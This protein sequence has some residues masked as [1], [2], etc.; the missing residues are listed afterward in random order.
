MFGLERFESLFMEN[1]VAEAQNHQSKNDSDSDPSSVS[2]SPSSDSANTSMTTVSTAEHEPTGYTP[3]QNIMDDDEDTCFDEVQHGFLGGVPVQEQLHNSH[4][5]KANATPKTLFSSS[6]NTQS[7]NNN[8]HHHDR[9]NS[10]SS[11][12]DLH[13]KRMMMMMPSPPLPPR[14]NSSSREKQ[15]RRVRSSSSRRSSVSVNG[16]S[17]SGGSLSQSL[18][19][20]DDS[21]EKDSDYEKDSNN[22]NSCIQSPLVVVRRRSSNNKLSGS[23]SSSSSSY[24]RRSSSHTKKRPTV[25]SSFVDGYPIGYSSTEISSESSPDSS[26]SRLIADMHRLQRQQH[27][28]QHQHQHQIISSQEQHSSSGLLS[29][30]SNKSTPTK[31][32]R[33]SPSGGTCMGSPAYNSSP[34]ST[35]SSTSNSNS[36]LSTKVKNNNNNNNNNKNKNKT[37]TNVKSWCLSG[38]FMSMVIFS[39]SGMVFLTNRAAIPT[40]GM[41]ELEKKHFVSVV[42]SRNRSDN[43]LS[44]AGLRGKMVLGRMRDNTN[45]NNEKQPRST[46]NSSGNGDN[47]VGVGGGSSNKIKLGGG[48]HE[49]D[50]GSSKKKQRTAKHTSSSSKEYSQSKTKKKN[51]KGTVSPHRLQMHM[52]PSLSNLE[53]KFELVDPNLYYSPSISQNDNNN[54]NKA[55]DSTIKLHHQQSKSVPYPRVMLLDPLLKRVTRKI[56][57]YPAD[58]SDNTQLYGTLPSD[59]ERLLLMEMRAPYSEGECVPMQEWQTSFHPS[60]NAM[61]ELALQTIGTKSD[62]NNGNNKDNNYNTSPKKFRKGE[63]E[64]LSAN[65]FGTG[66]FWRYA[67]KVDLDHY[68][69]QKETTDTVVL[70]TLK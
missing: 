4:N 36:L 62:N 70:K 6:I 18:L 66:G 35:S 46:D 16:T 69:Y 24:K 61:H 26:P 33:D 65:L 25:V 42:H 27:Q 57:A 14:N 39:L 54:N 63:V 2:P 50:V 38:T 31:C 56:K 5:R 59:D 23:S 64:G 37:T 44:A 49:H 22:N 45:V 29:S 17:S 12:E 11:S 41:Y 60:C 13:S 15:R 67:W 28:H 43:N 47:G 30:L 34:F 8:H 19:L 52:P 21:Y 3:R 51:T 7:N 40:T 1:G 10:D 53:P 48:K 55:D 68:D 20:E 9:N 58:F 32:G